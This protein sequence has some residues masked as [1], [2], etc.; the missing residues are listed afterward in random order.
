MEEIQRSVD[1]ADILS[2]PVV[3]GTVT[4]EAA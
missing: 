1:A 3:F 2:T 4:I